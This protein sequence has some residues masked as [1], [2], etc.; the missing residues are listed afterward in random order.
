M[1]PMHEKIAKS[2]HMPV[3]IQVK[4]DIEGFRFNQIIQDK[5]E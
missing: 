4:T 2:D 5:A 3:W 1:N